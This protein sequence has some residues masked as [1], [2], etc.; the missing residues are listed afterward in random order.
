MSDLGTRSRK[1]M[2]DGISSLKECPEN[3]S[4]SWESRRRQT[5]LRN[6][7]RSV[8]QTCGGMEEGG[9]RVAGVKAGELERELPV[10][11]RRVGPKLFVPERFISRASSHPS[12]RLHTVISSSGRM[13]QP[14][15]T[16]NVCKMMGLTPCSL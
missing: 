9:G 1:G 14:R 11:C 5:Q 8:R 10:P 13:D 15:N 3:G 2:R 16:P 7:G 12:S 4:R 6:V